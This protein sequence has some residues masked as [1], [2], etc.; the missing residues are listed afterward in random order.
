MGSLVLFGFVGVLWAFVSA[1]C[2]N[3]DDGLGASCLGTCTHED[4]VG[5]LNASRLRHCEGVHDEFWIF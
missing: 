5:E 2:R 3:F 4:V 1:P